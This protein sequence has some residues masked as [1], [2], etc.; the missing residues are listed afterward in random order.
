MRMKS[1]LLNWLWILRIL[2]VW[3]SWRIII[4]LLSFEYKRRNLIFGRDLRM[5]SWFLIKPFLLVLILG[6][7]NNKIIFLCLKLGVLGL[8]W[9]VP[10]ILN[11]YCWLSVKVER[12][13]IMHMIYFLINIPFWWFKLVNWTLSIEDLLLNLLVLNWSSSLFKRRRLVSKAIEIISII[14]GCWII[15]FL[16]KV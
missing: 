9:V 4:F 16:V 11:D 8:L 3:I 15:V 14:D 13:V 7:R 1:I 10:I 5:K 6:F 2:L 12:F